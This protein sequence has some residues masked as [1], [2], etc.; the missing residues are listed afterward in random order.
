MTRRSRIATYIVGGIAALL[1]AVVIGAILIARTQ[2]F[3]EFVRTKIISVTEEATGGRV[4]LNSF[5][6]DWRHLRARMTDFVI[7]GTEPAG[8]APLFRAR[9]IELRLKLFSGLKKAVDLQY[10][11]VDQPSANV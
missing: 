4:E 7:R 2:R 8:S 6:F 1:I 5:D 10:L 3:K 9:S 11:G